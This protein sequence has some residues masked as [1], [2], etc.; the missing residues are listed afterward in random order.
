MSTLSDLM[1][2]C[3]IERLWMKRT[4]SVI[5]HITSQATF[6]ETLPARS[7]ACTVWPSSSSITMNRPNASSSPK[8]TIEQMLSWVSAEASRASR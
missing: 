7:L 2:P 6:A 1:S 8:S 3:R 4:A 5:C